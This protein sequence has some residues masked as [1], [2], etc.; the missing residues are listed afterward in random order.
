MASLQI[1]IS[2]IKQI[3][4]LP[5]TSVVCDTI[6][7]PFELVSVKEKNATVSALSLTDMCFL[8]GFYHCKILLHWMAAFVWEGTLFPNSLEVGCSKL[9]WYL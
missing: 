6:D 7:N 2:T 1:F 8:I 5:Q 3:G 4:R 9:Y